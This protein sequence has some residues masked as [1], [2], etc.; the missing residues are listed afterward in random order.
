MGLDLSPP[1]GI[2]L[3]SYELCWGLNL[4]D[5]LAGMHANETEKVRLPTP[6]FA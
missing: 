5:T 4:R 1:L 2:P 6:H 3:R